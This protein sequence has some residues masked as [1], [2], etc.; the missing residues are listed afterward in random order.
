MSVEVSFSFQFSL[1]YSSMPILPSGAHDVVNG[2]LE[3]S[4]IEFEIPGV[5]I[6]IA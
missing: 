3:A 5:V 4:Q 2:L 1:N 6:G